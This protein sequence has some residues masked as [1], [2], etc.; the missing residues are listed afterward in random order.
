MPMPIAPPGVTYPEAGVTAASPA[1]APVIMPSVVGFLYFIQ[2]SSDHV[3]PATAPAMWVTANALPA[4]PEAFKAL[5]ALKP[6]QPN[7]SRPA[8]NTAY[9]RLCGGEMPSGYPCRRPSTSAAARA[10]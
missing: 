4:R 9:G 7:H 1:T 5:P 10:V 3:T 2:S 6:N 8:P